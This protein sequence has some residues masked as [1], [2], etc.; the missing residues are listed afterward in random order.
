MGRQDA[1]RQRN[2]WKLVGQL[3]WCTQ[4]WRTSEILSQTRQRVGTHTHGCLWVSYICS[5]VHMCLHLPSHKCVYTY[6]CRISLYHPYTIPSQNKRAGKVSSNIARAL[7]CF[8]VECAAVCY[9]VLLYA[10][11][12]CCVLLCVV[13]CCILCASVCFLQFSVS[14]FTQTFRLFPP[15]VPCDFAALSRRTVSFWTLAVSSV[16]LSCS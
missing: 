7:S 15:F 10:A 1:L 6:T 11:V 5:G 8:K 3:A 4:W 14:S 12:C 2:L 9:C 16:Y 13:C